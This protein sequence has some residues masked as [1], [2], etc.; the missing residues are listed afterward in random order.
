[1]KRCKICG[2]KLTPRRNT[3]REHICT[4]CW[5]RWVKRDPVNGWEGVYHA[6]IGDMPLSHLVAGIVAAVVL[7]WTFLLI[8]GV[9]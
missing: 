8:T 4:K 6:L 9:L 1:M 5:D 3:V 7:V 2:C